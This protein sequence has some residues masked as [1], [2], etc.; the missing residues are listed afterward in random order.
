[1]CL[2]VTLVG[3]SLFTSSLHELA[4]CSNTSRLS[5]S[6]ILFESIRKKGLFRSAGEGGEQGNE[7]GGL[8]LGSGEFVLG[9]R[10][11]IL[12]VLG[13]WGFG[14]GGGFCLERGIFFF[15]F[16]IGFWGG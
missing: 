1:M 6:H 4:S 11:K 2:L 7:Q 5:C 14:V 9:F 12:R 3:P 8:V 16:G 10:K 13:F 15:Y